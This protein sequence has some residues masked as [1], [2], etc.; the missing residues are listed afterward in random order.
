MTGVIVITGVV[1][2]LAGVMLGVFAGVAVL[3]RRPAS[4]RR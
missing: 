3:A 1:L 2:F 4:S